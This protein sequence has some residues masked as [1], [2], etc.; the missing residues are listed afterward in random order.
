MRRQAEMPLDETRPAAIKPGRT[1]QRADRT[2]FRRC[3]RHPIHA[4]VVCQSEKQKPG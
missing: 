4:D 2:Q 1:Y 3:R